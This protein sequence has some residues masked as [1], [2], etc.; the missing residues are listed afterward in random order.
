MKKSK[1]NELPDIFADVDQEKEKEQ[2]E[3]EADKQRI[4][5]LESEIER[6]KSQ[7]Q[8][9]ELFKVENETTTEGQESPKEE[10]PQKENGE[11]GEPEAYSIP[12]PPLTP[13][14]MN[15]AFQGI[16]APPPPPCNFHF[17]LSF[18]L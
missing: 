10:E 3:R 16:L 17:F 15:F 4:L 13:Q 6:L 18:F 11:N 14:K 5:E 2:N 9:Q 1:Q 12:V 8:S 7:Y